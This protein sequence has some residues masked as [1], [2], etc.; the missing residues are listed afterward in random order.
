MGCGCKG[1]GYVPPE[2]GARRAARVKARRERPA[3]DVTSPSYFH[4]APTYSGPP[5]RKT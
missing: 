2:A 4:T 1:S 5:K 3:T